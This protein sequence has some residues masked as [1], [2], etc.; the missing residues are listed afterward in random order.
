MAT[1]F[2]GEPISPDHGY[3]LRGAVGL[4]PR[5]KNLETPYFWKGAKWLRALEFMPRDR[6]GFW[7]QAGYHNRADV[8][9]EERFG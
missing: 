9:R 7:E 5:Q 4:I 6:R 1:H 2:N 8:W 3:P